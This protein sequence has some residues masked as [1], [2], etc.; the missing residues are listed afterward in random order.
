MVFVCVVATMSGRGDGILACWLLARVLL[1]LLLRVRAV[2]E[3]PAGRHACP[4]TMTEFP[5]TLQIDRQVVSGL[6]Q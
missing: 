6:L 1:L 2:L 3:R 5:Y 4:E